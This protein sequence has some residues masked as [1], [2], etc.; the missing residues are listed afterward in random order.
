MQP[1]DVQT[2]LYM[3]LENSKFQSVIFKTHFLVDKIKMT[4]LDDLDDLQMTQMIDDTDDLDYLDD[5][6][7]L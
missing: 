5:L 6:D 4:L 1:K 3:C 2:P 7:D